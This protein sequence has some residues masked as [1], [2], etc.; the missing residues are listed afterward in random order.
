MHNRAT[1]KIA[2]FKSSPRYSRGL[3]FILTLYVCFNSKY[4]TTGADQ[5]KYS[6]DEATSDLDNANKKETISLDVMKNTG[7]VVE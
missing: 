1:G 7:K 4:V 5:W 3:D 2:K 6:I